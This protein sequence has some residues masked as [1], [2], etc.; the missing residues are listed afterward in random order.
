MSIVYEQCSKSMYGSCL[1]MLV[2]KQD[3]EDVL[4]IQQ[5]KNMQGH[6]I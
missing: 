1:R 3:G 2:D 5:L 4:L 6:P